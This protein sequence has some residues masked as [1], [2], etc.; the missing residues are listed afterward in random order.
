MQTTT[1]LPEPHELRAVWRHDASA[2]MAWTCPTCGY[3]ASLGCNA[4][5]HAMR[6]EHP[7]P[8]LMSTASR[9]RPTS[10]SLQIPTTPQQVGRVVDN[11]KMSLEL[12]DLA[13]AVCERSGAPAEQRRLLRDAQRKLLE[14]L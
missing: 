1:A 5:H 10:P 14:S 4:A 9:P 3:Q 8:R 13:I 11:L 2:G 6:A 7:L 12:L